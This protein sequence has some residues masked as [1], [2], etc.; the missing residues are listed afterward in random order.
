ME[1]HYLDT[2]S[3]I[4][5]FTAIKSL[6]EDLKYFE[7]DFNFSDLDPSHELYSEDTKK[8]IGKMKLETLP[9]LDLEEAV[10]IRS[11]S[12][13]LNIKQNSSHGKHK[14]VQGHNTYTLEEY[15]FCL[16]NIE[17]KYGVNYSFTSNKH[18]ISK[19]KQKKIALNTF[20]GKRCYI[21]KY[22]SVPWG[23]KPS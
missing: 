4:F 9:E 8:V 10:I 2:D 1:L 23:Y 17:I 20:D 5:S 19:V 13:S 11:K 22:I 12:Y 7:E 3:F 21:D 6:I 16:E 14:G 15:K 18:D